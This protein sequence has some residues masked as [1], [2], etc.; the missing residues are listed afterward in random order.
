MKPLNIPK[1]IIEQL[2]YL[3]HPTAYQYDKSYLWMEDVVRSWTHA[4]EDLLLCYRC[5]YKKDTLHY[6][7]LKIHH[8]ENALLNFNSLNDL[9]LQMV[10]EKYAP[11]ENKSEKEISDIEKKTKAKSLRKLLR[12][13]KQIL[14][15]EIL[16]F[17]D[18]SEE[19]KRLRDL[20]NSKKHRWNISFSDKELKLIQS[21]WKQTNLKYSFQEFLS[22]LINYN[23]FFVDY[24]V[25]LLL[26]LKMDGFRKNHPKPLTQDS[27]WH[28]I[29]NNVYQSNFT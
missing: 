5:K 6:K 7:F 20:A 21:D 1:K 19:V 16:D 2:K 24:F 4:V 25:V 9:C 28:N 10:R 17:H 22:T 29:F 27:K 12:K 18:G 26:A 8:L 11:T 3:D 15:I 23:N 13:K 14:V